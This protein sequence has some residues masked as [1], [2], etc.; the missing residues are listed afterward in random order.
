MEPT[1]EF[2]DIIRKKI[3][4]RKSWGMIMMLGFT[5]VYTFFAISYVSSQQNFP[6]GLAFILTMCLVGTVSGFFMYREDNAY[7]AICSRAINYGGL[8]AVAEMIDELPKTPFANG[9]LRLGDKIIFYFF[10][11]YAFILNPLWLTAVKVHCYSNRG[12]TSFSVKIYHK[13]GTEKICTDSE[14]SAKAIYNILTTRYR[15][16]LEENQRKRYYHDS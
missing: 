5:V 7:K 15:K 14:E 8:D 13:H 10:S 12:Y 9:D 4:K 6:L 1:M 3:R 11:D 2:F 16:Q